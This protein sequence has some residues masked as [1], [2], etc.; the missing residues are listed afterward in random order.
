MSGEKITFDFEKLKVY[1]QALDFADFVF[2]ACKRMAINYQSSI[3]DQL[4]RSIV[5]IANNIAEGSGKLSYR[6]KIKYF[7]YALDSAKECIPP[8]T[9]AWRQK[10]LTEEEREKGRRYCASICK[11]LVKLIQY[12]ESKE[13]SKVTG[14][15][16]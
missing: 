11:M 1:Q 12:V 14:K 13:L 16:L 5:S 9:I 3:V 6:E 10:Q 4:Q 15:T 2:G 8:L 7:S